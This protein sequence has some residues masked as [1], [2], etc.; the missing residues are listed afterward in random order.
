MNKLS[1]EQAKYY[2]KCG[3]LKLL[4]KDYNGAREDFIK[5]IELNPNDPKVY[6]MRAETEMFL[7]YYS[8]NILRRICCFSKI[9]PEFFQ[10]Y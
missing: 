1:I 6:E 10:K 9:L 3:T 5:S 2:F 8:A 4:E 7:D